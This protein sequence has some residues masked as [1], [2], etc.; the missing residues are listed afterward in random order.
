MNTNYFQQLNQTLKSH[1]RAIPSLIIDLDRLDQNIN[2]LQNT[3]ASDMDFRIV[4]KSL[5]SISL[6]DY[7]MEKMDTH[8]L[9]VFHQP[10]LSKLVHHYG[11]QVNI[12]MG[13]PMPIQTA[14]YFYQTL[15]GNTFQAS[16]NLQWL[17]DTSTRL[18]QYIELSKKYQQKIL[19][20]LEIDVGLH[21]GGFGDLEA[22]SATLKTIEQNADHVE[23]T[24]FMGYD[25]HVAALPKFLRSPKKSFQLA[26]DFYKSCIKLVQN[27]FPQ[28]WHDKLTFNGAGSPTIALH[29]SSNSVLNDISAGS[30]LVKPTHFDIPTLIDFVPA[31]FIAT[32][33]L[34]KLEGTTLPAM[35]RMKGI[36]NFFKPAYRRTYFIYGGY[37]KAEYCYPPKTGI[38]SLFGASTNQT[39]LNSAADI[40]LEVD[41]FVFLRPTQSEFVFLQFGDIL[42]VRGN[43]IVGEWEVLQNT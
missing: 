41:D 32:P 38:N 9:M 24:G 8:K 37:W 12:L 13:K 11:N 6:I 39:M 19:V 30:G 1:K 10:F 15:E 29:K 25:P 35:E 17:I 43:R 18:L 22:L 4:V 28:L 23:F 26:N 2:A 27:D 31:C 16:Q 33:I 14:D 5:P 40:E 20:N 36:F 7:V 34:K 21:R 3:I 42:V